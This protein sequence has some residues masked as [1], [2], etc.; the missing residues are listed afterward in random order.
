M[1]LLFF[2]DVFEFVG[3]DFGGGWSFGCFDP[4]GGAE[5]FEDAAGVVAAAH[6][7]PTGAGDH[8]ENGAVGLAE[9]LDDG[10]DLQ[11]APVISSMMDSG[12][13]STMRARKTW[14]SSKIW[15]RECRPWGELGP[16]GDL[17]QAGSADTCFAGHD[18]VDIDGDFELVERRAN[19]VGGVLSASQTIKAMRE[20][21]RCARIRQQ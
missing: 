19:A 3:G 20:R 13:R 6:G 14:A 4:V 1:G 7:H 2:V 11:A 15:E 5:G 8:F 10:L 12:A 16:H 21:G 9:D 17:D 18:F